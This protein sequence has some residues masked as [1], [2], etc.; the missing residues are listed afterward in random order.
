MN[1]EEEEREEEGTRL[2]PWHAGTVS[3]STAANTR[4][5]REL[6]DPGGEVGDI[7]RVSR[8]R[9]V[10]ASVSR[11]ARRGVGWLKGTLTLLQLS[12]LIC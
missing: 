3:S 7:A 5:A 11:L 10:R 4:T 9:R 6:N 1:R 12:E 2:K 8:V